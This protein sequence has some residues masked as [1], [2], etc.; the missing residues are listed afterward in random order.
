MD[1]KNDHSL[2]SEHIESNAL[3]YEYSSSADPIRSGFIN[4]VPF[5]VFPSRLHNE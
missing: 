3:Y 4:K 1:E 2:S 5:I